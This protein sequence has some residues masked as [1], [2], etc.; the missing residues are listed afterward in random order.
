M[1]QEDPGAKAH[2]ESPSPDVETVTDTQRSRVTGKEDKDRETDSM[3]RA[4]R[5]ESKNRKQVGK[6]S[7]GRR[8]L[9]LPRQG[10]AP[11]G[12]QWEAEV[13]GYLH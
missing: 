12:L 7:L 2:V 6:N 9:S 11:S 3:N 1:N 8:K 5:A 10:Q 4:Q 13:A